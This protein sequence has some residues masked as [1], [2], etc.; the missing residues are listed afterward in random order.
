MCVFFNTLILN[1]PSTPKSKVFYLLTSLFWFHV[2]RINTIISGFVVDTP[3]ALLEMLLSHH[4]A[5]QRKSQ[6][7]GAR[8]RMAAQ[9]N[10]HKCT[11]GK[12]STCLSRMGTNTSAL[13]WP[14]AGIICV[15]DFEL[16]GES[17]HV[18]SYLR[19]NHGCM[20]NTGEED[21]CSRWESGVTEDKRRMRL[22]DG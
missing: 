11:T 14:P 15:W 10:W 9:T 18:M 6:Q 21:K 1:T 8:W 16:T 4:A 2:H 22:R 5:Y 7:R 3:A 19:R 12:G 17:C 13:R 20:A